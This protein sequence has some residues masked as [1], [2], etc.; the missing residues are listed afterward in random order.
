MTR[1]EYALKASDHFWRRTLDRNQVPEQ[2]LMAA[3]IDRGQ[4]GAVEKLWAYSIDGVRVRLMSPFLL[5]G[6]ERGRCRRSVA[7]LYA[8]NLK[9][10]AMFVEPGM[11]DIGLRPPD[12]IKCTWEG[13]FV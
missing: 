12:Y 4:A 3:M 6:H 2:R 7:K 1:R 13:A 10:W 8:K 5:T 11:F 9:N